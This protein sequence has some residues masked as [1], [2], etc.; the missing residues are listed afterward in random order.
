M[1]LS[2]KTI[3]TMNVKE[4]WKP[5]TIGGVTGIMMGAGTVYAMNSNPASVEQTETGEVV[6]VTAGN[7]DVSFKAAFDAARAELGPGGVFTWHGNVYNTYTADEWQHMAREEKFLFA[8]RVKPLVNDSNSQKEPESPMEDI[9]AAKV[10]EAEEANIV[11]EE[12][13]DDVEVAVTIEEDVVVAEEVT[14]NEGEASTASVASWD[15]LT[16]GDNDVRIISFGDV[17][18]G[19]GHT[20]AAQE[21]EVNGQRVAI[22]D[23]DKDG[24][25]DIAM[26]DLNHNHAMDE[27]EVIDLQTGEALSFTN[28]N[29]DTDHDYASND[30][31]D[32]DPTVL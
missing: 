12:E 3:T 14:V 21:L 1:H 13:T 22:I 28:S 27:G 7:D 10:T 15:D 30:M 31:A 20:V 19:E 18:L 6:K 24:T 23:V 16:D 25:A 26:S 2:N 5:V 11:E 4:T 32:I 9:A 29:Y 8:N 17:E